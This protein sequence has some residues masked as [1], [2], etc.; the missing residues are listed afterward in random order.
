MSIFNKNKLKT[1][2]ITFTAEYSGYHIDNLNVQ[3]MGIT[4]LNS[5]RRSLYE[6][7][8]VGDDWKI[9]TEDVK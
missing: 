9:T 5:L 6:C 1:K 8:V 3:G 2:K 7:G 4:F